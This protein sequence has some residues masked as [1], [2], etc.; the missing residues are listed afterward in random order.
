MLRPR[1]LHLPVLA[2]PL[3][4]LLLPALAAAQSSEWAP[5][6][7]LPGAPATPVEPTPA[8]GTPA[9]PAPGTPATP[10]PGTPPL[11]P[12][13]PRVIKAKEASGALSPTGAPGT[14]PGTPPTVAPAAKD[15]KGL[16]DQVLKNSDKAD[17]KKKRDAK[18]KEKEGPRRFYKGDLTNSGATKLTTA[19]RRVAVGIG[20]E[21]IDVFHYLRLQPEIDLRFGEFAFGLGAPLR[22]EVFN[23]TDGA[24]F[25]RLRPEDWDQGRDYARILRYA[26]WGRKE[27]KLFINVG[28]LSAA[29]LGHGE[30][31]KKYNP[32]LNIDEIRLSAQLDVDA[33]VGG[34]ESYVNDIVSPELVGVLGF[35]RPIAIASTGIPVLD[36]LSLGAT[37]VT[38][39]SAPVLLDR[40]ESGV[41]KTTTEGAFEVLEEERVWAGGVSIETKIVQNEKV[42]L[43]PYFTWTTMNEGLGSGTGFGALLRLNFGESKDEM[44]GGKTAQHALRFVLEGRRF[45]GNYLPTYFDTFYQLSRYQLLKSEKNYESLPKAA[46]LAARDPDARHMGYYVEGQYA[47]V[48][49]FALSLGWE[50]SPAEGARAYNAHLDLPI[51]D[52]LQAMATVQRR[53]LSRGEAPFAIADT[54]NTFA[55]AA[56]RLAP[57]PI[58]FVNLSAYQQFELDR[59]IGSY[60]SVRGVQGDV[61]L[62]YEF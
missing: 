58:L 38:D 14:P 32:N 33:Q 20:Y 60:S 59:S 36:R 55:L 47:L 54:D 18:A 8:P 13:A 30:I 26:T 6:P 34:F 40:F 4:A 46:A 27:E 52:W 35:V 7:A 50:D 51:S 10:A 61:E 31:M 44:Y 12:N 28:Q 1:A 43:K 19:N 3:L 22:I 5:P 57:L 42:D 16:A 15:G 23:S 37:Y 29:T 21:A 9:T 53:G 41:P 2:A 45:A 56:L 49:W 39:L 17:A 24:G 25:H 11:D 48:N 62:G